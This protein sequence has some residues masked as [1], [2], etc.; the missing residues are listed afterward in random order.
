MPSKDQIQGHVAG[1][2]LSKRYKNNLY[3]Y[4][5]FTI[6]F[7]T[8]LTRYDQNDVFEGVRVT[9]VMLAP[10]TYY[11]KGESDLSGPWSLSLESS[12]SGE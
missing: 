2:L 10:S 1:V 5:G 8:A 3:T 11:V 12:G 6:C 4:I 7:Y 9:R